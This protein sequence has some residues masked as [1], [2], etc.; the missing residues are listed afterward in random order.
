MIS[1]YFPPMATAGSFRAGKFARYLPGYDW[2]P[3][4]LTSNPPVG[5]AV[6]PNLMAELPPDVQITAI[7]SRQP[8]FRGST[9]VAR[10]LPMFGLESFW[11]LEALRQGMRLIREHHC[12]AIWCTALPPVCHL[13][14]AHLKCKTGLPLLLDYRDLWSLNPY[15]QPKLRISRYIDLRLE[16][17]I[18]AQADRVIAISQRMGEE[19]NR[20]SLS[21]LR[22]HTIPNGFDFSD[23]VPTDIEPISMLCAHVGSIY[24]KRTQTTLRFLD[25]VAEFEHTHPDLASNLHIKLVGGVDPVVGKYAQAKLKQARIE[26]TG[27]TSHSSALLAMSEASVLLLFTELEEM[28]SV[29]SKV[30][31]YLASGRPILVVGIAKEV[32][33]LLRDLDDCRTIDG[34]NPAETAE[35][36]HSLLTT[37]NR[38]KDVHS[39][40]WDLLEGYSREKLAGSLASL[41]NDV[42]RYRISKV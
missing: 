38:P 8:T 4:V 33:N 11:Y 17:Y 7:P 24:E 40:R 21:P 3:I 34:Q 29:T 10:F 2:Q 13:V 15:T 26:C 14:G 31:E 9:R 30:F 23:I 35:A 12:E 5:A 39:Q 32:E 37:K 42:T 18:L 28:G 1:Y 20:I 36:L 16:T 6:D 22:L 27:R 25:G 19:L 41:L